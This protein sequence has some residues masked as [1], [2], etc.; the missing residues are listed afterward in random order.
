MFKTLQHLMNGL[1]GNAFQV[2]GGN[3]CFFADVFSFVCQNHILN[4]AVTQVSSSLGVL[5]SSPPHFKSLH[6]RLYY[7][8]MKR[9]KKYSLYVPLDADH[10]LSSDFLCRGHKGFFFFLGSTE[11]MAE[12]S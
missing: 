8:V 7:S 12:T 11:K 3:S 4:I 6:A 2:E 1:I 9:R 10:N 5:V